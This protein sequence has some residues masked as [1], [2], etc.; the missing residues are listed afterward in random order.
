MALFGLTLAVMARQAQQP[1]APPRLLA[2]LSSMADG[3]Y[4]PSWSSDERGRAAARELVQPLAAALLATSVARGG[5]DGAGA[6]ES[7]A[8]SPEG[9]G[10]SLS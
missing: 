5:G 1:D 2:T 6:A 8:D 10:V 3:R 9:H 7:A 4:P